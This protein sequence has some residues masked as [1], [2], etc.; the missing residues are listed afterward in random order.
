MR[1]LS[2][3]WGW[4][5]VLATCLPACRDSHAAPPPRARAALVRISSFA[6]AQLPRD[7]KKRRHDATVYLDGNPV[8]FVKFHELPPGLAPAKPPPGDKRKSTRWSVA[9]YLEALRIDTARIKQVH[10]YGGRGRVAVVEGAELL[11]TR[12]ILRFRFT[13]GDHGNLRMEWP[14]RDKL[15]MIG[16]QT[17][18]VSDIA[19]YLERDPPRYDVLALKVVDD[20]GKPY[21]GIPFA[22]LERPGGTRV[23]IDGRFV[24]AIKRK[25]LPDAV[26]IPGSA[27]AGRARFSLAKYLELAGIDPRSVRGLEAISKE[28][29]VATRSGDALASEMPHL[30]FVMPKESK[31]LAEMTA[32]AP[33]RKLEA[34]LLTTG[35]LPDRGATPAKT[36]SAMDHDD[37]ENSERN[38]DPT[39]ARGVQ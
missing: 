24:S 26:V 17:D 29:I 6:V 1:V 25:T 22:P 35:K 21:P 11:K 31:G 8:A 4:L 2:G 18:I 19:V 10:F 34:L 30:E 7:K 23:Y 15:T 5:L 9:A 32:L 12:D 39:A 3:G 37:P 33:D 16:T 14:G 28:S 38:E 13:A 36:G 27:E 20:D